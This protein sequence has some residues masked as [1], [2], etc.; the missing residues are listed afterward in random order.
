MDPAAIR[1]LR[2]HHALLLYRNLRPVEI[3]M[4]PVWARPDVRH[5]TRTDHRR[6]AASKPVTGC[7]AMTPL[8][9]VSPTAPMTL[10]KV[11]PLQ[12]AERPATTSDGPSADGPSA[13][14]YDPD[15]RP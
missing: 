11:I 4:R 1:E 13:D 7:D 14:G 9:P 6:R 3:V 5:A 2:E 12:R 10:G 8:A 15:A